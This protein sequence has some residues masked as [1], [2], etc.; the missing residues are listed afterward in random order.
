MSGSFLF[1]ISNKVYEA[2][3]YKLYNLQPSV[4]GCIL[5]LFINY[6]FCYY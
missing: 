6:I 5:F 4:F 3:Y 2:V 1:I